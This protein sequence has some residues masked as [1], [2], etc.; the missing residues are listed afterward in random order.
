MVWIKRVSAGTFIST[1]KAIRDDICK[2][3]WIGTNSK[4]KSN[5]DV[6]P[7]K[8]YGAQVENGSR[9]KPD[10]D[11][12]PHAAPDISEYPVPEKNI[13]VREPS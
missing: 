4:V 6:S 7:I 9:T 8:A 12:Q 2:Y 1:F 5:K 10:I 11:S 13:I 3:S